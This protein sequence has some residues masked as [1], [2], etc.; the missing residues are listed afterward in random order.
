[1]NGEPFSYVKV[2][3]ARH[4][5][6]K[7]PPDADEKFKILKLILDHG[8]LTLLLSGVQIVV[9]YADDAMAGLLRCAPLSALVPPDTRLSGRRAADFCINFFSTGM[10]PCLLSTKSMQ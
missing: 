8:P 3:V 5:Y 2:M 4:I 10:Q 6:E 1:M 7:L 9:N